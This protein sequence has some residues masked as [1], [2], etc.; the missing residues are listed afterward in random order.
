MDLV[1]QIEDLIENARQ[2]V[3]VKTSVLESLK[4][5]STVAIRVRASSELELAQQVL[6]ALNAR[7]AQLQ[8]RLVDSKQIARIVSFSAP[9]D[10][11]TNPSARLVVGMFALAGFLIGLVFAMLR[12]PWGTGGVE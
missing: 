2:E 7:Y 1:Q 11:P 10:S 4:P 5:D 12:G 9:P 8:V 3:V 6:T